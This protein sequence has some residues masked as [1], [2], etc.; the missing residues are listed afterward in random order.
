MREYYIHIINPNN[1]LLLK[2]TLIGN[3][4]TEKGE[5]GKRQAF[6]DGRRA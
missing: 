3:H 6:L 1:V 2:T 4:T 5:G